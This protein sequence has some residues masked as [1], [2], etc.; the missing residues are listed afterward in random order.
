MSR[1]PEPAPPEWPN[2][3]HLCS[4]CPAHE[5]SGVGEHS[6]TIVHP[7]GSEYRIRVCRGCYEAEV[8]K[9]AAA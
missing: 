8:A 1:Q 5:C 4:R 3:L 6:L 7:G 9:T 2:C